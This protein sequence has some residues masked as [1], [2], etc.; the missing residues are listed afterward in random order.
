MTYYNVTFAHA[1]T[2]DN[3]VEFDPTSG[4]EICMMI[5]RVKLF[6]E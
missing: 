1:H 6:V 5:I 2:F 4:S 3:I